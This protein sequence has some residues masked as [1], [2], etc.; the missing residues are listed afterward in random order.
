MRCQPRT[1]DV[2][3]SWMAAWSTSHSALA[4][5]VSEMQI[6]QLGVGQLERRR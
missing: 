5:D 6:T 2:G 1:V 4:R 3:A